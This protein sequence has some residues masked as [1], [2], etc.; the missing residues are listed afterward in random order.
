MDALRACIN[1]VSQSWN[2][3]RTIAYRNHHGLSTLSGT[4]VNVQTMWPSQVSD[5]TIAQDPMLH[6]VAEGR[7]TREA[8][9]C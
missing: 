9:R 6:V 2:S 1:A 8:F 7:A 3:E 4:P 5:T